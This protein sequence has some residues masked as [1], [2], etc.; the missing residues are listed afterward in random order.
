MYIGSAH[1]AHR[2]IDSPTT[3]RGPARTSPILPR[4]AEQVDEWVHEALAGGARR[5]C[6]GKRISETCYA[7]PGSPYG[8]FSRASRQNR[9]HSSQLLG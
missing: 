2:S 8:S 5:V 6:G 3:T 4:E 7:A 1:G 9:T